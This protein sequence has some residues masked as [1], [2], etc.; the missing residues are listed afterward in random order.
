MRAR[1]EEPLCVHAC[2][3]CWCVC[4]VSRVLGVGFSEMGVGKRVEGKGWREKGGGKK[5]E[6]K[7]WR[8]KGLGEK[9]IKIRQK[10]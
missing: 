9:L 8:E 6:G 7:G 5:V 4:D 10:L 3:L 1:N 2:E